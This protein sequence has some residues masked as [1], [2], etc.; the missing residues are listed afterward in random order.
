[1]I[2]S[3]ILNSVTFKKLESYPASFPNMWNTLH[4][5]RNQ[6]ANL[7]LPYCQKFQNNHV[8]YLQ[9]ISDTD[10]N[11]T[12]KAIAGVVTIETIVNAYTPPFFGTDNIR[13][14]TN[15]VITLDSDYKDKIVYF[16]ATQ[17]TDTLT[18]E[19]IFTTDLTEAIN[20]GAI[21]YIKYTNL[22]RIESD[23]DDRFICWQLLDNTGNY[24][25]FFIDANDPDINNYSKTEILE[26]S[27]SKTILS[28]VNYVG[29]IL[30]TSEIPDYMVAKI[31]AVSNLDIFMVNGIQ[32]IKD[33][34]IDPERF[35][36]STS[37]QVSLN[38][39]Q[40][41]AI[42]INVD[43]LGIGD[44]AP[45]IIPS[46][47][48]KMYVGSVTTS[49]P[50]ETQIKAMTELEAVKQ[51]TKKIYTNNIGDVFCFAYPSSF[52][53]LSSAM[54]N[55]GFELIS[56]FA[57]TT[58]NFTFGGNTVSMNVYTFVSPVT[59]VPDPPIYFDITYKFTP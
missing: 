12:L 36:N 34:E 26:G 25:D 33:G 19:P 35:G 10:A 18:S 54:S 57:K 50:S 28:A 53:N 17:G 52:G 30:K 44:S 58:M 45:V 8:L 20:K 2:A 5:Q 11:I 55:F 14:Y 32:Y 48:T 59:F 22:D 31:D 47:T 16:T 7:K 24:L 1:M 46:V 15:F 38:L 9:F 27:Q 56:G 41:L 4:S 43:S 39:T 6:S 29:V 23:L 42:G 3:S 21:K 13:Y 51:D 37:H 49:S 40:K